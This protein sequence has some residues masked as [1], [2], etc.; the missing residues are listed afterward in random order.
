MSCGFRARIRSEGAGFSDEFEE[1]V[2]T[3]FS[4][5]SDVVTLQMRDEACWNYLSDDFPEERSRRDIP[6]LQSKFL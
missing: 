2:S 4:N 3:V 1:S 6:E 5:N